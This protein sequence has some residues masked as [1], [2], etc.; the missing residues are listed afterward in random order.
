MK[1]QQVHHI[2][3]V[4]YLNETATDIEYYMHMAGNEYGGCKL[5][6]SYVLGIEL[7]GKMFSRSPDSASW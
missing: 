2:F 3:V 5:E 7:S 4:A 1:F 6:S